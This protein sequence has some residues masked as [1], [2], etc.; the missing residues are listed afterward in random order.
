[1]SRVNM[2]EPTAADVADVLAY[3]KT[4]ID[5]QVAGQSIAN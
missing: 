1:M 2:N 4:R 5:D 3:L